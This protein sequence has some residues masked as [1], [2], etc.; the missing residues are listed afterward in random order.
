MYVY[1]LFSFFNKR[2]FDALLDYMADNDHIKLDNIE[3]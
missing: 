3:I 2:D 1:I